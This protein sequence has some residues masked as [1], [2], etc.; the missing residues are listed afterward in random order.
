LK[1]ETSLAL[2]QHA[3][4]VGSHGIEVLFGL[5]P[6]KTDDGQNVLLLL[7]RKIIDFPC[8]FSIDV[9]GIYHQHVIFSVERL[10]KST[11]ALWERGRG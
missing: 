5:P 11:L 1:Q 3:P 8:D 6:I 7:R 9:S 2:C 4:A 10:E